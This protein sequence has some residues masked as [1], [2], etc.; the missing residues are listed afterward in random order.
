MKFRTDFVTNSSSNSYCVSLM[1]KPVGKEAFPFNL[2]PDD[3]D[4]SDGMCDLRLSGP[5][6]IVANKQK[7]VKLLLR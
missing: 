5:I 3:L 7:L 4:P 2:F 1:V 6:D